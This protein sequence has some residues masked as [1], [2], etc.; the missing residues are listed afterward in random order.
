MQIKLVLLLLLLLLLLLCRYHGGYWTLCNTCK[1][2]KTGPVGREWGFLLKLLRDTASLGSLD[3]HAIH[4][5]LL[6]FTDIIINSNEASVAE[7]LVDLY[8]KIIRSWAEISYSE[9]H[10]PLR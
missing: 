3:Y 8:I 1:F 10:L 7:M 2:L 6:D 5:F 4:L 9:Q